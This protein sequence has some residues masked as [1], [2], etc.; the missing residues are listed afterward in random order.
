[1]GRIIKLLR[2]FGVIGVVMN[3]KILFLS[4]LLLLS[5]VGHAQRERGVDTLEQRDRKSVV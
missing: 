4:L 2:K 5:L 1:M 3:R